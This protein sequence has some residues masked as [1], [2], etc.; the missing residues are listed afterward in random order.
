MNRD[1]S[2]KINM[3][4]L[5]E[6]K[7]ELDQ[8]KLKT[9]RKILNRVH[10]KI[11]ITSRQRHCEQFIFFVVPEYII[12]TPKYDVA[13]CIAFIIDKLKEN[14]FL[15]TYTH[16]NLLFISWAHYYDKAK[17]MDIKKQ[18]G[19]NIDGLGNIVKSKKN[20]DK[21]E[22]PTNLNALIFNK[23]DIKTAAN[24]TKSD[25]KQISSYKPTGNLIYNTTLLKKIE[26]KT[27]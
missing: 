11:Q 25:Y 6:R 19:V 4:N 21:T 5:F 18:Y 1:Y 23:Q 27:K 10:T 2:D 13:A 17:R 24:K 22:D 16:P 12:G 15:V 14:G 7:R 9:F 20:V 8:L 26:D 3:D